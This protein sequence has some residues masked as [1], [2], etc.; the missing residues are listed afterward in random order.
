VHSECLAEA[1]RVE[2]DP[3]AR[4]AVAGTTPSRLAVGASQ[5]CRPLPASPAR[6][7]PPC[8]PAALYGYPVV[9][10]ACSDTGATTEYAA[11]SDI[12]RRRA[13]KWDEHWPH[14][15]PDDPSLRMGGV[16]TSGGGVLRRCHV[17]AAE[18]CASLE[19][20]SGPRPMACQRSGSETVT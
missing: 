3:A 13:G 18:V 2:S 16:S 19:K 4:A 9:I 15:S 17:P 5:D 20:L 12:T 8:R 10:A 7:R 14:C 1:G 11:F 6:S